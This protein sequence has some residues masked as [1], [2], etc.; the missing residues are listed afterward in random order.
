MGP[1]VKRSISYVK[2]QFQYRK[3]IFPFISST[4][5]DFQ[6]C[7]YVCS[8]VDVIYR[9]QVYTD[10]LVTMATYTLCYHACTQL[11]RLSCASTC[12]LQIHNQSI[13]QSINGLIDCVSNRKNE[14]V[15]LLIIYNC[16]SKCI[17]MT[18]FLYDES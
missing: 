16:S 6:V 13:S 12:L 11:V 7:V 8:Q 17:E 1:K 18:S 14:G 5:Q 4:F 3:P 2:R 10:S 15:Q 9:W